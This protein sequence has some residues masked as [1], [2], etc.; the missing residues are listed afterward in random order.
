MA[1]KP[2]ELDKQD[3]EKITKGAII[4]FSGAALAQLTLFTQTGITFDYKVWLASILAVGVNAAYK[5]I[6]QTK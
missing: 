5:Y 3:L 2:G 1:S 4:A 6:T